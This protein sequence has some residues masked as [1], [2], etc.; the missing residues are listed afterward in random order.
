M[1]KLSGGEDLARSDLS[2]TVATSIDWAA[3]VLELSAADFLN[4]NL[5]PAMTVISLGRTDG[6]CTWKSACV[7]CK[8]NLITL[9]GI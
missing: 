7:L 4:S 8:Q 9:L 1:L 2:E 5:H 6:A 3:R